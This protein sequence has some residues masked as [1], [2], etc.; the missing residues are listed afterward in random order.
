MFSIL[1][2][3]ALA[4][5]EGTAAAI[6]PGAQCAETERADACRSEQA[7][8]RPLL[9]LVRKEYRETSDSHDVQTLV[10][11][12][13]RM[14]NILEARTPGLCDD[15]R[16]LQTQEQETFGL[17]LGYWEELG[18]DGLLL[19]EAHAIDPQSRWRP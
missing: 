8:I 4:H 7:R 9:M 11:L 6:C 15:D 1:L 18:Y 14:R 2:S 13:S 16:G 3:L 12:D 17:R 19:A 5:S 10:R